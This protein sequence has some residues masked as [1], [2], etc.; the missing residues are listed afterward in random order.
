VT[1]EELEEARIGPLGFTPTYTVMGL[2]MGGLCAATI[3]YPVGDQLVVIHSEL[4]PLAQV[5][6]RY[7]ELCSK[8]RVICTVADGMPYTDIIMYLQGKDP[9][10]W[11]ALFSE[12]KDVQLYRVKQR[13]EDEQK[14][15]YGLRVVDLARDRVLDAT[16]A[17]VRAGNLKFVSSEETSTIFKHMRD[18]KRIRIRNKHG[19]DVF[20]WRKSANGVDHYFFSSVY[21]FIASCIRGTSGG[22]APLPVMASKFRHK[23]RL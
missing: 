8:Y 9:N 16:I 12:S 4:I 21:V 3:G 22:T 13:E 5:K 17:S 10:C 15:F 18:L 19:E 1:L 20:T 11:A 2:D 7:F 14:A 23:G 6:T